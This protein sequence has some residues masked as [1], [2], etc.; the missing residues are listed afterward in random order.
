MSITYITVAML[1]CTN[2]TVKEQMKDL[3]ERLLQANNT[4]ARRYLYNQMCY[5]WD[6]FPILQTIYSHVET[7][8]RITDRFIKVIDVIITAHNRIYW[9]NVPQFEDGVNQVYLIRLLDENYNLI[10]SK[11]GTTT[12]AT[13]KRMKQHLRY[14][15]KNGVAYCYVDRVWNCGDI[16]PEGLES[17]FRARYIH[18]YKGAFRKNDRFEGVT[19]DLNE[20]DK[21]AKN[22]LEEGE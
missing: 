2:E 16:D 13:E 18:K 10:Y 20:A 8:A 19:F 15:A 3:N 4:A 6:N 22:Y 7:A 5:L 9:M 21:I 12:K 17:E 1:N 11:V 14:Y